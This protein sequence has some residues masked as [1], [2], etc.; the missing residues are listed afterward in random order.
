LEIIFKS[1]KGGRGREEGS[2][3]LLFNNN[4]D[5]NQFLFQDIDRGG[6]N[7]RVPSARDNSVN[8]RGVKPKG[9][10]PKRERDKVKEKAKVKRYW[11]MVRG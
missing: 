11:L 1:K 6:R 5:H 9:E 3:G 10:K 4:F 8:I 2:L 7:P